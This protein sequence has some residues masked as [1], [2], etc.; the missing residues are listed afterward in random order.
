V[1]INRK[2]KKFRLWYLYSTFTFIVLEK[3]RSDII[4]QHIF[5]FTKVRTYYRVWNGTCVIK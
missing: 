4:Y 2:M 1:K 3:S 5:C